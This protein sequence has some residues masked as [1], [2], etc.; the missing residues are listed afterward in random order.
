MELLP[1]LC[2]EMCLSSCSCASWSGRHTKYH[3]LVPVILS[4][5]VTMVFRDPNL[6]F[7]VQVKD[8][9][10]MKGEGEALGDFPFT[11][12]LPPLPLLPGCLRDVS[13]VLVFSSETSDNMYRPPN[14]AKLA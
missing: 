10:G 5:S 3:E 4:G 11:R 1:L 7:N 12:P 8:T 13:R 2:V 6:T 14:R 9:L